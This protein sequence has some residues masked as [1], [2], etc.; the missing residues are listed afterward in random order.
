MES[1]SRI[2]SVPSMTGFEGAGG[3]PVADPLRNTVAASE[4]ERRRWARELHD[5]TLQRLGAMRL[6]LRQ[7]GVARRQR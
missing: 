4:R 1:C 7:H 6:R 2:N 3:A 5:E